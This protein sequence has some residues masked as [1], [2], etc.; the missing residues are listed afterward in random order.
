MISQVKY[1]E[2]FVLA[3]EILRL[4]SAFKLNE[5][6]DILTELMRILYSLDKAF[7]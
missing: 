2:I 1:K 5:D 6:P 4:E 7:S 3:L